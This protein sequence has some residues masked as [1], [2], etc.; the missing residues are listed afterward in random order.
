MESERER[1]RIFREEDEFSVARKFSFLPLSRT[2]FFLS[3]RTK[4]LIQSKHYISQT[5]LLLRMTK[6]L[7]VKPRRMLMKVWNLL[8]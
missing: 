2:L 4:L 3:K 8:P 6:Y 5:P 1:W 7:P